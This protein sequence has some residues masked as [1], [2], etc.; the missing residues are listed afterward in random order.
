MIFENYKKNKLIDNSLFYL[1]FIFPV[2]FFIGSFFV[3]TLLIIIS[4]LFLIDFKN[5]KKFIVN[6]QK[7]ILLFF[8]LLI[9]IIELF[10]FY[11]T[12]IFLKSVFYIRFFILYLAVEYII[13]TTEFAKIKKAINIILVFFLFFL[14]DLYIQYFYGI[15]LLG[16]KPDYCDISG[17]NCQRFSGLFNEE[18]IAGS[19]ISTILISLF[20]L[21]LKFS[22]NFVYCLFPIILFF[23]IY[24]TGERSSFIL[25]LI[26]IFAFYIFIFN[27]FKRFFSLFFIA[28]IIILTLF[29]FFSNTSVTK[30]YYSEI[31][32]YFYSDIK[33]SYSLKNFLFTSWGKHYVTAYLMFKDEPI[34]GNGFKSFRVKCKNYSFLDDEEK[35]I[36]K[37]IRWARCSSHPH[38]IHFELLAEKGLV[39]YFLFLIFYFI[40]FK[41]L[42]DKK[43]LLNNRLNLVILIFILLLIFLPRPT[44]SIFS[45]T[46]ASLF[47]FSTSICFSTIKRKKFLNNF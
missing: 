25:F 38:N 44:G 20:F 41:E 5:K 34:I 18:L 46:Y 1:V 10:N 33:H 43:L 32:S 15:N 22:N 17:N 19:F 3:N 4:V 21:K 30:R 7:I 6:K 40:N 47:W 26:F 2:S 39:I 45:T 42:W 8:F 11:N 13:L 14:F 29:Y 9:P 12:E 16:F 24:I 27:D 31:S 23:T 28:S 37:G 35:Q 36:Y